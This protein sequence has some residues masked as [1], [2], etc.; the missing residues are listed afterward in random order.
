M[1]YQEIRNAANN[2]HWL[3]TL[4]SI[5][6]RKI[7]R[8]VT[9]LC[10]PSAELLLIKN[11]RGFERTHRQI[12][13]HRKKVQLQTHPHKNASHSL[14]STKHSKVPSFLSSRGKQSPPTATHPPRR[15][16]TQRPG[17]QEV[18][19]EGGTRLYI[20]NL[21]CHAIREIE[22]ALI[23]LWGSVNWDSRA[24]L[25]RASR[26]VVAWPSGGRRHQRTGA[27]RLK[28]SRAPRGRSKGG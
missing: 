17:H 21:A 27:L 5:G 15:R 1:V 25:R 9:W 20:G 28:R 22:R 11:A 24:A 14:R 7:T 2:I 26:V 6:P 23:A 19:W 12:T 18:K 4:I 16:K 10:R 13:P 8:Q 3:Q